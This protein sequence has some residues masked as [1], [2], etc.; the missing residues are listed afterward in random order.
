MSDP[1]MKLQIVVRAELA[2]AEIRARRTATRST[3]FSVA[4]VFLL[5]GL[6]MMTLAVY[7][8]LKNYMSPAWAAFSVA[9]LDMLLGI[10]FI[11]VAKGSGPSANEEKLAR[12]LREMAYNELGNDI[13]EV[14]DEIS[15]ISSEISRIRTG[16]TSFTKGAAGSLGPVVSLLIKA[17][18]R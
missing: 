17:L 11:L 9:L 13:Q 6:G 14:K 10:I 1:I 12:E 15:K 5:I 8:G 4:L 18:K 7:N 16:I 3:Y 2:L